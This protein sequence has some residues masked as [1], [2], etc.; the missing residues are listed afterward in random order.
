MVSISFCVVVAVAVAVA[1][2]VLSTNLS[3]LLRH[4]SYYLDVLR[5]YNWCVKCT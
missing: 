1:V 3:N 5:L 4:K 2:A